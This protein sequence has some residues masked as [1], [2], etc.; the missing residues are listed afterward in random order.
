MILKEIIPIFTN[1][2]GSRRLF[3]TMVGW[4]NFWLG[5]VCSIIG[6]FL[7][8]G[9]SAHFLTSQFKSLLP[10]FDLAHRLGPEG[11]LG[12]LPY[13]QIYRQSWGRSCEARVLTG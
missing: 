3:T 13:D 5:I 12:Q 11:S 8:K 4:Q 10:I 9:V 7:R 6:D 2:I 1:L